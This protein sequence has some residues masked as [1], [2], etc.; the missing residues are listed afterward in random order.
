M[1]KVGLRIDAIEPA[2]TD[3]TVQ[4]CTT[5][6]SVITSEEDVVLFTQADGTKGSFGSVIIRLCQAIIAVVAQRIPLV[7]CISE[8]L[9]QPGFL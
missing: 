2:R 4:Q 3:Q 1:A 9:A 5:L 8:R 6:T 7:Q